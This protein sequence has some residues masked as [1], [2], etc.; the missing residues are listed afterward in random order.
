MREGTREEKREWT[1]EGSRDEG[2]DVARDRDKEAGK[3][4]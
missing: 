4:K 2:W 3:G 1:G